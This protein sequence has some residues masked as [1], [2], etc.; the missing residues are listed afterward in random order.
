MEAEPKISLSQSLAKL[1]A[2]PQL[3]SGYYAPSSRLSIKNMKISISK[4]S[5][6]ERSIDSQPLQELPSL[7]LTLVGPELQTGILVK[8]A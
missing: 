7:W 2:Y 8:T 1:T 5:F 6:L 4:N 3:T